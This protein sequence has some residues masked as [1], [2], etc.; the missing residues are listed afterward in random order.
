MN[1]GFRISLALLVT[2]A[3]AAN[4][5]RDLWRDEDLDRGGVLGRGKVSLSGRPRRLKG[6]SSL[7]GDAEPEDLHGL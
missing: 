3:T 2:L 7:R 5:A 6:L 4:R 1:S